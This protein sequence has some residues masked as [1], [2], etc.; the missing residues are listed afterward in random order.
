MLYLQV[1]HVEWAPLTTSIVESI[2]AHKTQAIDK[3]EELWLGAHRAR[4]EHIAEKPRH[5]SMASPKSLYR[6][7]DKLGVEELKSRAKDAYLSRITPEVRGKAISR[8]TTPMLTTSTFQIALYELLS[9]T[10]SVYPDLYDSVLNYTTRNFA[11]VAKSRA[12]SHFA[13][14]RF[15]SRKMLQGV[16]QAEIRTA[17]GLLTLRKTDSAS[18]CSLRWPPENLRNDRQSAESARVVCESSNRFFRGKTVLH[19]I[20]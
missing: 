19:E 18:Q 3:Y 2:D 6:L 13:S 1:G 7:A 16:W 15:H 12:M 14:G 8:E 20:D 4:K 11:Q 5:Q 17:R 10:V 9:K